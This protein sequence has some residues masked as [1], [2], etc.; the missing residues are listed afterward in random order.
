MIE[1]TMCSTQKLQSIVRKTT[2]RIL[3][4]TTS[5]LRI[6]LHKL[7]YTTLHFFF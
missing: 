4:L 3:R 7:H 1:S 5:E 2:M 6:V